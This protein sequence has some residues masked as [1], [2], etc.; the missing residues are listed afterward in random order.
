MKRGTISIGTAAAV[1]AASVLVGGAVFATGA[2][3][4]ECT[5]VADDYGYL[6]TPAAVGKFKVLEY[7]YVKGI[8]TLRNNDD[9][10]DGVSNRVEH[11]RHEQASKANCEAVNIGAIGVRENKYDR[12]STEP[13]GA[14][15]TFRGDVSDEVIAQYA[16]TDPYF[17]YGLIK[18]YEIYPWSVVG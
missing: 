5:V 18:T 10:G 7:E 16:E 4:G 1:A 13:T 6:G 11:L 15:V 14:L 3:A 12:T 9:N 2:T 8:G 17:T